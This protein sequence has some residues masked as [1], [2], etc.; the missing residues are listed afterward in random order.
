M[1]NK[2][3]RTPTQTM[4]LRL[5]SFAPISRAVSFW[6]APIVVPAFSVMRV[7]WTVGWA[8]IVVFWVTTGGEAEADEEAEADGAVVDSVTLVPAGSDNSVSVVRSKFWAADWAGFS[9]WRISLWK[10]F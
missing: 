4:P 3:R 8:R 5:A 10:P 9:G 6:A 7:F 2:K 1:P